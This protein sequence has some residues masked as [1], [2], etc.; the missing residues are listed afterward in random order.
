MSPAEE[1]NGMSRQSSER[2]DQP[3]Q[4]TQAPAR[5]EEPEGTT[6]NEDQIDETIDESFPASDP[7]SW[8]PEKA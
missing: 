2:D 5:H 7:P 8:T 6:Y 3:K 4:P 1:E